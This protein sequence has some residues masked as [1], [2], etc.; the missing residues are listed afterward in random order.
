MSTALPPQP[1]VVVGGG[2]CGLLCAIRLARLGSSALRG[3]PGCNGVIEVL[4]ARPDPI[5]D[6]R[7]HEGI[8]PRSY[9][10]RIGP[11]VLNAIEQAQIPLPSYYFGPFRGVCLLQGWW[12]RRENSENKHI[13][14]REFV[15]YHLLQS[16]QKDP[17][18]REMIK[19][20]F[21]KKL[22]SLDFINRKIEFVDVDHDVGGEEK[23]ARE[24]SNCEMGYS[25]LLAADGYNS[26]VRNLIREPSFKSEVIFEQASYKTIQLTGD[27]T[28]NFKYM[29]EDGFLQIIFGKAGG[30]LILARIGAPFPEAPKGPFLGV[31]I[32]NNDPKLEFWKG[33]NESNFREKWN[34]YAPSLPF[35]QTFI[36]EEDRKR[37]LAAPGNCG[38]STVKC[39]HLHVGTRIA[40]LGDAGHCMSAKLGIGLQE[41]LEDTNYIFD[42][43]KEA[44]ASKTAPDLSLFTARRKPSVDA[45]QRL[46]DSGGAGGRGQLR[47]L[48]SELSEI[49]ENVI[50]CSLFPNLFNP[51]PIRQLV[52]NVDADYLDIEKRQKTGRAVT[53][54]ILL[55][56][57][58][59]GIGLIVSRFWKS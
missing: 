49:L 45:I 48:F 16:I 4:E 41:A 7:I 6:F 20:R 53:R 47:L 14:C 3:I 34:A 18:L 43:F 1:I 31:T 10:I 44:M 12:K 15:V 50:Y 32:K 25:Y 59:V 13:V 39:S 36:D 51:A 2:P 11:K 58:T 28:K 33:W 23:E 57:V 40:L 46:N 37:F 52:L 19:V 27:I 56:F 9:P 17:E 35:D 8:L 55:S 42:I 26:S 24:A 38:G 5:P 22:V 21:R 29:K 30:F 54:T